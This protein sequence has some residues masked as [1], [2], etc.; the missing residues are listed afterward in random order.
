MTGPISLD[1]AWQRLLNYATPLASER[2]PA[3]E[4]C[5]RYLADDVIAQRSQP[6][7][8]LSAMDGYAVS[9]DEPWSVVG[10]SRAG[11]PYGAS[12]KS[13]EAVLISTGA[14]CPAGTDAILIKENAVLDGDM[15]RSSETPSP[16]R[17]IRRQGFDFEYGQTVLSKGIAIGPAQIAVARSAGHRSLSVGRQ[18]TVAIIEC[19]DELVADPQNCPP[20]RLPA[21]NGAML[22]AM[23]EGCGARIIRIGPVS[24]E[25]DK[26]AEA[27]GNAAAADLVVTSGGAS[28]GDHDLVRPVLLELGAEIDFWKVAIRPG[29]PLLL[30][31]RGAQVILGLPGNPVS[32]YV[33]AFLFLLPLIRQ[34]QAA[35]SPLPHA[36]FLPIATA[37]EPGGERREFL[38]GKFGEKG[39]IPI[40]ERDSSA[41]ASLSHADVLI[42]RAIDAPAAKAGMAVPC[43]IL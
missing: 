37:I 36:H 24:D 18:P 11:L 6:S 34:M 23:A 3:D 21:S 29:K 4:C 1:L 42:D 10:E 33:T 32:S 35:N 39:I 15:V 27:F 9:G 16:G 5:G 20:D 30:A 17:H 13:R 26:L 28:V 8:D 19:G 7:H 38:R 31:R 25:A 22:A 43:Y 41:L 2:I 12:L 40:T 14:H